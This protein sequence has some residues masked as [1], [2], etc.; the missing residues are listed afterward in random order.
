M[1]FAGKAKRQIRLARDRPCDTNHWSQAPKRRE[2]L[3]LGEILYAT[4]VTRALYSSNGF[5]DLIRV[6]VQLRI[7]SF[8][9]VQL[10]G[11]KTAFFVTDVTIERIPCATVEVFFVP[12]NRKGYRRQGCKTDGLVYYN[13]QEHEVGL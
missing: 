10:E 8:C 6:E 4:K 13:F 7:I 12:P 2:R 3:A 9:G 1:I 11:V 5:S